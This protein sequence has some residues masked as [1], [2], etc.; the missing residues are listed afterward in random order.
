MGSNPVNPPATQPQHQTDEH[1]IK[2]YRTAYGFS[3]SVLERSSLC[4]TLSSPD[5]HFYFSS[6]FFFVNSFL[7]EPRAVS[8]FSEHRKSSVSP[9]LTFPDRHQLLHPYT[10]GLYCTVETALALVSSH[11]QLDSGCFG[12][13]ATSGVKFPEDTWRV[14]GHGV[15]SALMPQRLSETLYH[16]NM[17]NIRGDS[18]LIKQSHV[19]NQHQHVFL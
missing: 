3:A 15:D 7:R 10:N 18:L 19:K 9:A 2:D 6:F 16:C 11:D 17:N 12:W 13:T 4:Q 5:E 1:L 14:R 8:C